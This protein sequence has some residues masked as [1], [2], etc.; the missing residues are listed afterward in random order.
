MQAH[1]RTHRFAFQVVAA[2]VKLFLSADNELETQEWIRL[3]KEL[4]LP[5][6]K[7]YPDVQG[8][9][10]YGKLHELLCDF[11][12]DDNRNIMYSVVISVQ[13]IRSII[14]H[15]TN[16]FCSY[17]YSPPPLCNLKM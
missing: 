8:G 9:G 1:S 14:E 12:I 10:I 13:A 5:E 7:L 15:T 11:R 17:M 3:M 6:R 16:Y 4:V 2:E